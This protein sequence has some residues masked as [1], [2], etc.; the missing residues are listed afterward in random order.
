MNWQ[1]HAEST[2]PGGPSP[3]SQTPGVSAI[4]TRRPSGRCPKKVASCCKNPPAPPPAAKLEPLHLPGQ[5]D[6]E[7]PERK[8]RGPMPSAS[9]TLIFSCHSASRRLS[10]SSTPRL[11]RGR[12][13]ASKNSSSSLMLVQSLIHRRMRPSSGLSKMKPMSG[14]WAGKEQ[15][16]N[17]HRL[18]DVSVAALFSTRTSLV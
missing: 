14:A 11:R 9:T 15:D 12:S 17:L 4:G 16:Q 7:L 13:S 6:P 1:V 3:G 8:L 10:P 2:T 18:E 5:R